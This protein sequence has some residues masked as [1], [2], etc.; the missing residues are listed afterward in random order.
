MLRIFMAMV[1][2]GL[3]LSGCASIVNGTTQSVAISTPP[4]TGARCDLSSSEGTWTVITPGVA[5]VARSKSDIAVRCHKDGYQPA[6]GVISSSFEAWTAGNLVFGGVVGLGVDAATGAI[7]EYP[8]S[9]Q[10]P[11]V[12]LVPAPPPHGAPHAGAP[13]S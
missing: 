12:P 11:M 13:V 6:V 10:L 8:N 9:Y 4:V 2:V 5:T 1:P 3:A 7:N